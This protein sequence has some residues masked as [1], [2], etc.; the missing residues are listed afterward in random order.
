LLKDERYSAPLM[1]MNTYSLSRVFN[2][3]IDEHCSNLHVEFSEHG[4]FRGAMLY[5]EKSQRGFCSLAGA[6][7]SLKP[8]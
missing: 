6:R 8:H 2:V 1:Q 4:G 3:L 5:F 7:C